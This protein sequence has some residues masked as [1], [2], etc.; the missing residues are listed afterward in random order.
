MP[1]KMKEIFTSRTYRGFD[2][3]KVFISLNYELSILSIDNHFSQVKGHI[4]ELY[5]DQKS[6]VYWFA[7]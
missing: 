6:R 2:E 1:Q 5:N 3:A 7:R 4:L